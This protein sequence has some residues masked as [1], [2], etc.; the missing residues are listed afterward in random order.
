M[1]PSVFVRQAV[2][3]VAL[4]A[5]AAE[6]PWEGHELG[7]RRLAAMK[8]RVEAG[9]LRHA[10][11]PL[12]H[13]VD[14]REV[15]GLMQRRKRDERPEVLQHF[16]SNDRRTGVIGAAVHNAVTDAD[17]VRAGVTGS[18]PC[19]HEHEG[20]ACVVHVGV[21][22]MLTDRVAGRVLH[23]ESRGRADRVHLAADLEPP[24]LLPRAPVDAELQAR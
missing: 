15:V 12:G 2:E 20:R 9:D 19:R 24:Q 6:V 7:D 10:G 4:E 1:N 21:H 11:Q 23:G 22:A 16:G 3:P 14:G 17:H 8:A 5:R 13:R 18:H